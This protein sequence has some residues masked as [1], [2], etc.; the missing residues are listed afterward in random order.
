MFQNFLD[1][2]Q[3]PQDH[4]GRPQQHQAAGPA[5]SRLGGASRVA[6][7]KGSGGDI[8]VENND[9]REILGNI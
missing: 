6:N 9:K 3:R 4:H 2:I 7:E 1:V 5:G 8:P